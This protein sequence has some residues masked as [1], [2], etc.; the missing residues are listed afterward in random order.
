[1]SYLFSRALVEAC[2]LPASLGG[3]RSA[4]LNLISTK[5]AFLFS[6]KTTDCYPLSPCGMTF[7]RLTRELGGEA[8]IS[9]LEDSL[10]K[11][12]ARQ[13]PGKTPRMIFGRKC[14]G[15]WQM[16]LPGTYL[17]RTYQKKQ[18]T[19][20]ATTSRRWVT[21]QKQF[22]FPRKTWVQTTFGSGTGYLHTPTTQG[23][24][25]ADSMQ[26]HPSCREWRKVFGKV[27]PENHEWLMGW[28]IGWTDL[29]PLETGRFRLWLYQ[30][31][32]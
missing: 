18:S 4:L 7:V 17:P 9:S 23:N 15:L 11:R 27:T 29:R 2:L 31:L 20:R 14:S 6:D 13:Q 28:P 26:K 21:K 22:P 30:H 16:Q 25:C 32:N 3:I 1:M 8:L 10:A 5:D 12:T 19:Q 24:Y